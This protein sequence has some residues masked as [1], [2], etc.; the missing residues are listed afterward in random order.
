MLGIDNPALT[1]ASLSSSATPAANGAATPV[2]VA[3]ACTNF[4]SQPRCGGNNYSGGKCG[5]QSTVV[6]AMCD[7]MTHYTLSACQPNAFSSYG[8]S[9]NS[10]ALSNCVANLNFCTGNSPATGN[11]NCPAGLLCQ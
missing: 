5:D 3:S 9:G 7:F 1:N 6:S 10:L 2:A 11:G 8:T 4:L